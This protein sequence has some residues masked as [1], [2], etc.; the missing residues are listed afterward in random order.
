MLL[1]IHFLMFEVMIGYSV[2]SEKKIYSQKVN[3]QF[4]ISG[5]QS[6]LNMVLSSI[7]KFLLSNLKESKRDDLGNV[8]RK[9]KEKQQQ[10][11]E[12]WV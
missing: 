1:K 11:Y 3:K 9:M 12:K 4:L 8:T 10:K 2:V 7:C 5:R 6:F